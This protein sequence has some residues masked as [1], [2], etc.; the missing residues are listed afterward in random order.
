MADRIFAWCEAHW[1][2][3]LPCLLD[4]QRRADTKQFTREMSR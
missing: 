3:V 4:L 1:D 2:V